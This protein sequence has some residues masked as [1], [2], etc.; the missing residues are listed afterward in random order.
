MKPVTTRAGVEGDTNIANSTT[1]GERT[2]RG[3]EIDEE[4]YPR[5]MPDDGTEARAAAAPAEGGPEEGMRW[6]TKEWV[7]KVEAIYWNGL[8]TPPASPPQVAGLGGDIDMEGQGRRTS[9]DETDAKSGRGAD[10]IRLQLA[11]DIARRILGEAVDD[12]VA[13]WEFLRTRYRKV[14]GDI[15]QGGVSHE[16][17]VW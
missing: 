17:V 14:E 5:P 16:A 12:D 7:A 6:S 11:D 9:V 8:P 15:L 4:G 3:M 13:R 10:E 1:P 2:Q